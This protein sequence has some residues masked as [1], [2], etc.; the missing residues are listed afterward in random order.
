MLTNGFTI[1]DLG[2]TVTS[3]TP[4][5]GYNS[6][7]VS[8]TNLAGTNFA[9]GAAVV[10][11]RSGVTNIS[12]TGI[13]VVSPTKITCTFQLTEV[14]G[15]YSVVVIN[16]DGKEGVLTD[17]FNVIGKTVDIPVAGNWNGDLITDVGLFRP[18]NGNW[19]LD[20]NKDGLFDVTVKFGALGDIPVVGDWNGDKKSDTGVF[21]PS[22]RQFIFNTSPI[23]RTTFGLSTDIPITGDWNGDGKTDIGVFRPSAKQ[24]IFN[25]V[26]VS[27]IT[28]G[29]IPISP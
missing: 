5:Y 17:G 20:N 13:T 12:A 6:T 24:F 29:L 15:K 16:P 11:T 21:R 25:T 7:S 10:L 1:T 4:N 18:L 26:P 22:A 23:T 19:Y 14:K 27:R 3:I 8:I 9:N 28:F 2:L